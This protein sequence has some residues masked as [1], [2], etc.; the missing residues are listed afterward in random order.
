MN[1]IT[2]HF[3]EIEFIEAL[4]RCG[5]VQIVAVG[6]P[7]LVPVGDDPLPFEPDYSTNVAGCGTVRVVKADE[8]DDE[9]PADAACVGGLC[10]AAALGIVLWLGIVRVAWWVVGR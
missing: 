7:P 5:C 3:D 1:R 6:T 2:P 10:W 9:R 8:C 4:E